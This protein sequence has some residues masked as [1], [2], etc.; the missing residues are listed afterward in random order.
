[1]IIRTVRHRGLRLLL[2]DDNSRFVKPELLPRVRKI[3]TM[4]ILAEDI[5]RFASDAPQGWRL[6][7]LSGGRQGVWS[8]SVSG[9]WRITFMEA[10]GYVNR[11][12]LE[13]YH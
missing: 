5:D 10:D 4:L 11:L 6:H 8:V 7:R 1:M 3:L 2:E 9:N 13:D 12:N